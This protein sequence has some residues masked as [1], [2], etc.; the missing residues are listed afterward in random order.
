MESTVNFLDSSKYGLYSDFDVEKHKK[1]FINYLE[2]LILKDGTIKYAVPSHQELAIRLACDKKGITREE[3]NDECPREY[4][5]DFLAWILM[6][7]DSVA[8][9]NDFYVGT[10]NDKQKDALRMLKSSGVYMGSIEHGW[11]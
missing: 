5:G 8:V 7:T 11:K 1:T 9:W 10:P 4:Y 6:Q 3:L 2:V